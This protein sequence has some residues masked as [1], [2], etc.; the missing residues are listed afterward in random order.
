MPVRYQD[1]RTC[2]S[3][4]FSVDVVDLGGFDSEKVLKAKTGEEVMAK[5]VAMTASEINYGQKMI[6]M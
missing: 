1:G 3:G 5:F 4:L 6:L 2:A